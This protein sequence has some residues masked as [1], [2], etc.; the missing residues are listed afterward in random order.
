MNLPSPAPLTG[1]ALHDFLDEAESALALQEETGVSDE[2]RQ[3]TLAALLARQACRADD[4]GGVSHQHRLWLQAGRPDQAMRVLQDDGQGALEA[5]PPEERAEGRLR[6]LFWCI[7]AQLAAGSAPPALQRS[8]DQA[9][10]AL[11]TQAGSDNGSAWIQL[12][13]L[14]GQAGDHAR[15]RRC[16]QALH[17]HNTSDPDRDT[18]RAWDAA[19]LNARLA[20]SHQAEGR[21]DQALACARAAV[22]ALATATPGQDVDSDDWLNLGERLLAVAPALIDD[23]ARHAPSRLPADAAAPLHRKLAVQLARLR[24]RA[25]HARGLLD[26]A[27]AIAPAGRFGLSRD[28]AD[29]F[30]ALMLDWLIEAGRGPEAARLAFELAFS[31]REVSGPHA[32]RRALAHKSLGTEDNET[33]M[34]WLLARACGDRYEELQG[35]QPVKDPEAHWEPCLAQAEQWMPGNPLIKLL[36]GDYMLRAGCDPAQILPWLETVCE[37]PAFASGYALENLYLMRMRVHGVRQALALPFVKCP[38]GSW[39]YSIG[40]RIED[41]RES[42]PEGTDW[43][44]AEID[45]MQIR[46]YEQGLACFEAFFATGEG[47]YRSGD[48]HDYSMLCNNLAIGY[49]YRGDPQL[50]LPVHAKGIA[51]SSFA[52]HY[53]GILRCHTDARNDEALVEAADRLWHYATT[54]G[55]GR[56]RPDQYINDVC[57]ALEN[58]SRHGESA[59]WR[60]RLQ[61]WWEAL[62]DDDR[63]TCRGSYVGT[64]GI[65]LCVQAWEQPDDIVAPLEA[66]LPLIRAD[67]RAWVLGNASLALQRAGRHQRC[68]EVCCEILARYGSDSEEHVEQRRKAKERLGECRRSLRAQRPWWKFWG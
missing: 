58:L 65:A 62:D 19:M 32:C 16:V 68:I 31:Q 9:E 53:D 49:R 34:H 44:Q 15:A 12:A 35:D 1:A 39:N 7:E 48:V 28:D 59:I 64:L 47:H 63:E 3:S 37:L 67:G 8:L 20:A 43:P 30:G 17:Q 50:A 40:V 52:E 27:L 22:D 66:L 61:E 18:Y 55:Y 54:Y 4:L 21:A 10:Q 14:S 29:D 6:L 2:L 41:L 23:I 5:L 57:V 56:H 46:Y 42:L 13:D 45:A 60:Q 11:A 38:A 26:Q 51:A 36:R 25:L 24:A 33:R